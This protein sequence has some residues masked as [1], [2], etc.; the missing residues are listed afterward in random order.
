MSESVENQVPQTPKR[1]KKQQ[2]KRVL[3]L[4]TF[5]FVVLGCAWLVYW[6]LVLRHHQSTDDAYVAGNQIQ[7]MAQVSGSVTHVNVDNTDFVKQGQ[8][9]VELDPTDAE[10]A[11][12]RAKTGL[13][14][15]VRQTH[16][17]IINSKQY[18]AN[19][20]LR[21]TEL[22][23]AQSDL[24]RR[25][26]LGSANAIGRE[27]V[28]HARDAVAT[29]KAALEV[30]RQQYQ[31]NQ[32]MILD[33]PLEKQPAIQQASVEM[34]DAWLALQRTKIVSPIDGYVSRRSVQIGA[35]ISSTSALMAVVPA[36]HL[37]V[38]A[39]FKE[40]QLANMRIGQPATV[41]ADIYGDDV[42]YQGKVVGL[43]MGT[44]SA[45]SLL[46]AQNATG[47]WIKVVQ[48]LPVRIEL[49]PQQVAE[50]P[51][52]IGLSALVNVD[53]ANAEGSALAE[54]SRTTPAYQSDALTLDLTP[55]NQEIS[56]II[57]A[58]AG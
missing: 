43:D 25:E 4:L 54:T 22:N 1:N 16:Q 48:R 47:N 40:T 28:Q 34:R 32:A 13:A 53:T 29:A 42:V 58:N 52:R 10:Q 35:R 8:V 37:W 31:A 9:L 19:I 7:I 26:A 38:D 21:Q 46:P 24:S 27:E 3:S 11:L 57:Q 50:H 23:K 14:N 36:N 39:N 49:D 20:E 2:R 44:G 17:L 18:Q 12:E 33:T 55:V 41:V 5:I 30:A 15:S 51:L 56:A 45:F 6:F